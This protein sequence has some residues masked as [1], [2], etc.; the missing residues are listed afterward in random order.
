MKQIW[1]WGAAVV[2]ALT[3][4]LLFDNVALA[5]EAD[6]DGVAA[7]LNAVWLIVS[8][9]VVFFMQAGFALLESGSTRSKNTIN[10]MMKNLLDF[11]VATVTYLAVGYA[12]MF[13]TG[14]PIIGLDSFF[15]AEFGGNLTNPV[16]PI[17][18]L[19][20]WFFQLVFAGTAATIVSGAVAERTKFS[21]YIIFSLVI[22]AIIYP[23]FGHWVWGGGWL[24]DLSFM[25]LVDADGNGVAF[26]DF[27]GSTVVHSVGG[28]A[29]FFG[30]M[31]VGARRGRFN[32]DGTANPIP[33]HSMPLAALGVFILWLGWF[34]FNAG[35]QLAAASLA[36]AEAIALIATN[37]TIAAGTGAL[38]AMIYTAIQNKPDIS[39][40]FNGV[41]GGLVAIT[42]PCAGVT[43]VQALIIGAVGGCIV[44]WGAQML[45][46]IKVDDP[47]GA[48]PAHL[49]AG[50]WG[51]LAV[52][53]FP[54]DQT[55]LMAQAVGVAA[56]AVWAGGLS[57]IMFLILDNAMGMRVEP[58]VEDRGLDFDE[59]GALAY[60]DINVVPPEIIKAAD[61]GSGV[62]R[63]PAK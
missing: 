53:L 22:T 44:V 28:W 13:G 35:S 32:E 2:G 17:P 20:F 52:G 10:I 11:G 4:F 24:G 23:I 49:M 25:G 15:L 18:V 41:I 30:A 37:T 12:F 38:A 55:Q 8:A 1:K 34:G 33:G 36:D 14:T 3:L 61:T 54:F 9:M 47:V 45:E 59:H 7:G 26:S 6:V 27:A 43:P 56:C 21:A 42:A 40:S 62:S 5:Q 46:K 39:L 60:P 63:A 48:V 29:A 50:V 51:T 58:D 16:D 57:Y 19:A 31:I